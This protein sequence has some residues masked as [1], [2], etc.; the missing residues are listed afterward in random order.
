M[1]LEQEACCFSAAT[2]VVATA[3]V[4]VQRKCKDWNLQGVDLAQELEEVRRGLDRTC[5]T[6]T[7]CSCAETAHKIQGARRASGIGARAQ[8]E[9]AGWGQE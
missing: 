7:C 9:G 2:V 4:E 6:C 3:W 1:R 5:A 8:K